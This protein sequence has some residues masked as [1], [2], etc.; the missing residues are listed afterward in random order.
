[1]SDSVVPLWEQPALRDAAG[2]TLRPGGFN[3]TDR[4]AEAVGILPGVRVLDV[5]CGLGA[6]VG[7]L[8]SRFGA[9]AYGVE[10]SMA[11]I[12]RATNGLPLI[13]AQGDA[14][15]FGDASFNAVFCE[16]VLSLFD[17]PESGLKEFYRVLEPGG[18]LALS[19]LEAGER[20]KSEFMSCA[21]GAVP[22]AQ[23][24]EMVEANGF[25]VVLVEDHSRHLKDLA[26]KLIF[27]GA[28]GAQGCACRGRTLGYYLMI[29]QKKGATDAG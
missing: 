12:Q 24:R 21:E 15:P 17:S 10:S 3:L 29:A 4:A 8:R 5:G 16:C 26:A 6:T 18:F 7:R 14:L 9:E 28:D 25:S 11:Q 27:A 2:Q 23:T 20:R 22:L 1:M 19:D 13:S